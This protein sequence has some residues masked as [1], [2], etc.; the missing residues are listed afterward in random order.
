[1]HMHVAQRHRVAL[2]VLTLAAILSAGAP[3]AR[4]SLTTKSPEVLQAIDRGIKY[5]ES[6]GAQDDKVGA[7]ALIGIALLKNG[8]QP[9]HPK[10]LKV[11]AA[12]EKAFASHD[13]KKVDDAMGGDNP[14]YSTG[15]SIMFLL[16][17]D[18]VAHRADIEYLLSYFRSRQKTHGGWGYLGR[19]TGDTSMTQYG[20]LSAWEAHFHGINISMDSIEAVTMWLLKTQDPS[21]GYG[22]QGAPT[23]NLNKLVTQA[24][25]KQSMTAAGLGS[26]YICSNLL[27]MAGRVEKP[28]KEAEV[29]SV[30]KEIKSK[31]AKPDPSKYRSK[32]DAKLVRE[33]QERGNA[34]F[35]QNFKINVGNYNYYYLYALERYKSIA[36]FCDKNEEKDPQWYSDVAQFL[37]EKQSPE[38]TW[39]AGCGPV[40]DTAFA[41]L[42]LLRSMRKSI[43]KAYTFGD[44]TL[45]GGKGIPK[46]T[47]DLLIDGKTGQLKE[48]KLWGEGERLLEALKDV[49]G[50]DFDKAAESLG[51]LEDSRI[52]G[53]AAKH[54]DMIRRLVSNRKWEARLG[55][56]RAGQGAR[57]GQ[58]AGVDLRPERPHRRGGPRGQRRAAAH[59]PEPVAGPVPRQSQRCR[60]RAV[61]EQ[62]KA[63][64]QAVRPGAEVN[65]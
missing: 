51:E 54:A 42:F 17:H 53:L 25:V 24:D 7:Q 27:G 4:R 33:A 50:K 2:P 58:R 5:L 44:G 57:P 30:L 1:M 21:G 49:D 10:V 26:L 62:W 16:E 65:L 22:Y 18:P 14:A 32:I 28:P 40:P 64:Y 59:Q 55:A 6:D 47:R 60:R 39:N 36:E 31:E 34:W 38:G 20:V 15:L 19:V 35:A 43:Q 8:A 3:G 46:D 41:V 56:V 61:I 48:R 63:W 13:A 52:Q 12:V 37:I 45:I 23:D 29:P 11:L 9:D